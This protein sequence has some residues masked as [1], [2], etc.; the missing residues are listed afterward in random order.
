MSDSRPKTVLVVGDW[1]VDENWTVAPDSSITSTEPLGI[2]YR[3]I[4]GRSG[5]VHSLSGAGR[6][7]H[8]LH[9]EA[10]KVNP[11]TSN[12]QIN[13]VGLGLWA[14]NDGKY[15]ENL[16]AS[17]ASRKSNPYEL[18][19]TPSPD[20]AR[21]VDRSGHETGVTMM[22]LADYYRTPKTGEEFGTTHAYQVFQS[23]PNGDLHLALR[24]DWERPT[25]PFSAAEKILA[26]E[27][28][29][30]R[31]PV[32]QNDLSKFKASIAAIVVKCLG[33]GVVSN[34]L[35]ELVRAVFPGTPW[36]VSSKQGSR[37]NWL[38]NLDKKTLRLLFLSSSSLASEEVVRW[39]A[40]N[41]L[42]S[43]EA[44]AF[45]S[46][47]LGKYHSRLVPNNSAIVAMPS[48]LSMLALYADASSK[49]KGFKK[50]FSVCPKNLEN[51][52]PR[53]GKASVLF[54]NLVADILLKQNQDF[55]LT[56]ELAAKRTYEWWLGEENRLMDEQQGANKPSRQ[57]NGQLDYEIK[58]T[59]RRQSSREWRESRTGL[60]IVKR[61][62]G[63]LCF[64]L[65]RGMSAVDG[66][67][68]LTETRRAAASKLYKIVKSFAETQPP[69]ERASS[70][71]LMDAPGQGKSALVK[72]LAK[73]LDIELRLIDLS[74]MNERAD[75][76]NRLDSIVTDQAELKRRFLVFVDEVD[77]DKGRWF[78]QFLAPLE[79]G[80]YVHGG[81]RFHIKPCVW[82]FAGST[83]RPAAK[84]KARAATEEVPKLDD[85]KSRLTDGEINLSN[86]QGRAKGRQE[87]AEVRLE[88]TY[89]AVSLLRDRFPGLRFVTKGVLLAFYQID[90][91][92]EIRRIRHLVH[93]VQN[94]RDNA[95][96]SRDVPFR[97]D[98]PVYAITDDD[99]T[100]VLICDR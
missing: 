73:P 1:V 62:D 78:A 15:L 81:N 91:L 70:C 59:P 90:P 55:E 27:L 41:S 28:D 58:V 23:Q 3:S 20:G 75:L 46:E 35:V 12:P 39:R 77:S 52:T 2:S 25:A 9:V 21:R 40:G 36:F 31:I 4:V 86:P 26:W 68:A 84:G 18:N 96:L 24:L 67:V 65:W 88:R 57:P 38:A 71:L 69:P 32:L 54:G 66:Y 53:I 48:P 19:L 50:A 10:S 74:Q 100:P 80:Y 76:T 99:D 92:A 82:V 43:Y 30:M 34:A 89:I 44:A 79:S 93:Q 16:V 14:K 5:S 6:V 11:A 98:N 37:A 85:F 94:V 61:K 17:D 33:K 8:A 29:P 64:D 72:G 7:A 87:E 42:P 97:I 49:N 83:V 51:M 22:N 60:G 13:L 47:T 63:Q 45:L 95:V 56:L